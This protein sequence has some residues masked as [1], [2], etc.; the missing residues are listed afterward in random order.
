MSRENRKKAL[1][2]RQPLNGQRVLRISRSQQNE[3]RKDLLRLTTVN[4]GSFSGRS[5]EVVD[6]FERR[7]VDIGCL[8]EVMDQGTRVYR[9]DEK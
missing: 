1:S 3:V 9:G 5:R 7:R 4:E 6:M 2:P 8:Q